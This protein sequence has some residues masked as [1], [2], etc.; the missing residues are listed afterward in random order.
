MD[1]KIDIFKKKISIAKELEICIFEIKGKID[2]STVDNLK[3]V[4]SNALDKGYRNY[5]LIMRDVEAIK[6][7]GIGAVLD[8]AK[9]VDKAGGDLRI[10]EI[11]SNITNIFNM[12]SMG[13]V[14]IIHGTLAEAIESFKGLFEKNV[15]RIQALTERNQ[16]LEKKLRGIDKEFP[17][18][19][20][21]IAFINRFLKGLQ[22]DNQMLKGKIEEK[23][24]QVKN[25]RNKLD[26][27][28]KG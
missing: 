6:S 2:L 25:L 14:L 22:T 13:D 18:T 20:D 7:T 5:V 1:I 26:R 27:Y 19:F 15:A 11:P 17:P 3:R 12:L 9:Q 10:A 23:E 8:F 16:E 4:F 21:P 28:R 24:M